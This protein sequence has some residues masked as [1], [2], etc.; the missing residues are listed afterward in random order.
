MPRPPRDER[1]ARLAQA[2]R[3][4]GHWLRTAMTETTIDTATLVERARQAG[5]SFD[6]SNVSKWR[7]G[8]NTAD[9]TNVVTIAQVLGRDPVE[10]LHAAGHTTIAE[11][12]KSPREAE[13]R[14][15]IADLDSQIA[16]RLE[17]LTA[18]R[19]DGA[20]EENGDLGAS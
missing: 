5:A 6:R 3:Q 16:A 17:Q 18:I 11:A 7:A 9:P 2:G 12:M 20:A 15:R 19:G 1:R 8:D 13:L 10:A 14:A 4:W